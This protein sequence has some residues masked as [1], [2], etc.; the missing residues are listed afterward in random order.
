[1][2]KVKEMPYS[3]K[4]AATLD[5]MRL[6]DAFVPPLVQ[7][8]LGD[9]G[10]AEL[11][12]TWQEGLKRI[13][14]DASFEEKYEIAYGNWMRKWSS[15]F[16][17]VRTHFGEGGV[18]EFKRA[19]VEALK[20]KGSGPALFLLKMVR[21]LSPSSAFSMIAKQMAYQLQV[22]TPFS[23][24][25]L[26]G[27]RAVFNA[28]RCKILDFPSGEDV[29]LVGCQSVYPMWLAEQLMVRMKTERQGN[30][31]TVTLIPLG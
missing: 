31:C 15:A 13:P 12:R 14:E 29:C 8:H 11:Q 20:R 21:A 17:F 9:E 2:A 6:L 27:R 5:Y 4:Y 25:E 7:K 24:S 10:V 19:D 23:V 3:E 28:P 30:S 1:M 18:E 22:F 26:T 16:N